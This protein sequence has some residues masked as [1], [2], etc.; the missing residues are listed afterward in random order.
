VD[1][2]TKEL[3]LLLADIIES[4]AGYER[5]ASRLSDSVIAMRL[6]LSEL[7]PEFEERYAKH[8]AGPEVQQSQRK[9]ASDIELLLLIAKQ[10]RNP[11]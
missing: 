8:L 9:S 2:E 1:R 10:L 5:L 3:K 11:L 6:T 4:L 7:G